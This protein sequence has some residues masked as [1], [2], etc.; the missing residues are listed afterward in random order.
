MDI[1]RSQRLHM[2]DH[3]AQHLPPEPAPPEALVHRQKLDI[4]QGIIAIEGS[5]RHRG[6]RA[7]ALPDENDLRTKDMPDANLPS[8]APVVPIQRSD[9]GIQLLCPG[10]R[11]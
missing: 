9:P 2:L 8:R 11:L 7:L 1:F 10:N 4:S 5:A 3:S 6:N